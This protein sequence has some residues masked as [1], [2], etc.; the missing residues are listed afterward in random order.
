M[1][2]EALYTESI[3]KLTFLHSQQILKYMTGYTW[4]IL[5]LAALLIFFYYEAKKD[6]SYIFVLLCGICLFC[7]LINYP[8][9]DKKPKH[10]CSDLTH[11]KCDGYCVCDGMECTGVYREHNLLKIYDDVYGKSS[12][13][14]EGLECPNAQ[15][16][17]RDYQ[18]DI[19]MDTTWLYDGDRLVGR[20]ITDESPLDSLIAEDNL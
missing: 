12:C 20:V 4:F 13:P 15:K 16:Y 11:E 9:M 2:K 17:V 19:H 7:A 5:I 8:G 10:V 1:V 18:I 3:Y 14:Y 6:N